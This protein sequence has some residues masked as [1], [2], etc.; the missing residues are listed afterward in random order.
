VTNHLPD[1]T[2][3][4]RTRPPIRHPSVFCSFTLSIHPSSVHWYGLS[5]GGHE[6]GVFAN[7]LNTARIVERPP[8][9]HVRLSDLL[10][11][12][13]AAGHNVSLT[14][15]SASPKVYNLP[16]FRRRRTIA[17][18]AIVRIPVQIRSLHIALELYNRLKSAHTYKWKTAAY[19][20]KSLRALARLG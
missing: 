17:R 7:L 4:T 13:A 2:L 12:I 5:A 10:A 1:L 9:P 19:D 8:L 20:R 18:P 6:S 15:I 14:A 3:F 11:G 16:A